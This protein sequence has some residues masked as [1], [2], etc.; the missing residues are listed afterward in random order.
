MSNQTL[1]DRLMSYNGVISQIYG[2]Y[3]DKIVY[4]QSRERAKH[5][6]YHIYW[7]KDIFDLLPPELDE[8][9]TMDHVRT[10]MNIDI[11]QNPETT[12]IWEKIISRNQTL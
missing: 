6:L 9:K 3:A 2:K 8:Q 7:Y 12:S 4:D 1:L 11:M 5:L 10:L